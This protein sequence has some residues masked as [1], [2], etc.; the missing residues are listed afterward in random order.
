MH[1]VAF[2]NVQGLGFT[3]LKLG[4]NALLACLLLNCLPLYI[5]ESLKMCTVS[6]LDYLILLSSF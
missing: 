2:G 1:V 4:L 6:Q 3:F 5:F